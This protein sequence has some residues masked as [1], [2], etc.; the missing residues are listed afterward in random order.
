[1]RSVKEGTV[2]AEGRAIRRGSGA[3]GSDRRGSGATFTPLADGRRAIL[4][5]GEAH[6]ILVCLGAYL[7][8]ISMGALL[9][10]FVFFSGLSAP[11]GL[12]YAGF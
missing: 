8:V 9:V 12:I 7:A 2:G 3:R 10:W 4:T 1:M 5:F 6:P 11:A